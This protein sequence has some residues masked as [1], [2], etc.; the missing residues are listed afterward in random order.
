MRNDLPNFV[1]RT[2]YPNYYLFSDSEIILIK[3]FS[4]KIKLLSQNIG[5]ETIF[6]EVL[7]L[8]QYDYLN[9]KRLIEI[10]NSEKQSLEIFYELV[11]DFGNNNI[12]AAWGFNFIVFD[13]TN[14]W[15]LFCSSTHELAILGCNDNVN[16]NVLN[17][18]KPYEEVSVHEKMKSIGQMIYDKESRN[19]YKLTLLKNYKFV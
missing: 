14:T 6:V 7:L 18:L 4:K 10:S 15:E 1:L 5:A 19:Q 13:N 8:E 9:L 17:I 12:L 11:Y 3:D 16:N 2:K